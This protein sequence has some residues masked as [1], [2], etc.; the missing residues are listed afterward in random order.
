MGM[1]DIEG[2][3]AELR[4]R[5]EAHGTQALFARHCGVT[6]QEVGRGLAG[7]P[8]GRLLKAMK[9]RQVPAFEEVE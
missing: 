4:L 9:L 6:R 8:T 5:V 2:F 3:K 1:M 7:F